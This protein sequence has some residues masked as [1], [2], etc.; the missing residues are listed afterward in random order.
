M[1]I[2]GKENCRGFLILSGYKKKRLIKTN[3]VFLQKDSL[4]Q[5][6]LYDGS[7]GATQIQLTWMFPNVSIRFM[8]VANESLIN[9]S[10]YFVNSGW[11]YS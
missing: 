6:S 8:Y 9:V 3:F 2:R 7:N 1:K 5:I 10:A 4:K 11:D